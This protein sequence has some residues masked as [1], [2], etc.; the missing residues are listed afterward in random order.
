MLGHD[1][2]L[3]GL[4]WEV[5][6]FRESSG[7]VVQAG[8]PKTLVPGHAVLALR[9]AAHGH[10]ETLSSVNVCLPKDLILLPVG[11]L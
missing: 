8:E 4:L 1:S 3:A 6:D 5:I 11:M 2:A 9:W 10:A 7:L